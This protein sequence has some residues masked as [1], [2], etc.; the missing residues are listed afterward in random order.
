MSMLLTVYYNAT[1]LCRFMLTRLTA[2]SLF[3]VT[4]NSI[5]VDLKVENMQ[6]A[7]IK[8]SFPLSIQ[9]KQ[10]LVGKKK[11]KNKKIKPITRRGKIVTAEFSSQ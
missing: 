10:K 7:P 6:I 3:S 8:I 11:E 9:D 5:A 4:T 2:K 1:D